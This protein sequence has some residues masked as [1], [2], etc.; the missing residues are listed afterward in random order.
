MALTG[1][2]THLCLSPQKGTRHL[3]ATVEVTSGVTQEGWIPKKRARRQ[4]QS[5]SVVGQFSGATVGRWSSHRRVGGLFLEPLLLLQWGC[6]LDGLKGCL[7]FR[8]LLW[9][10]S[11]EDEFSVIGLQHTKL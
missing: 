8:L 5:K 1:L 11:G 4:L 9:S 3:L 7:P 10:I 6:P 2:C